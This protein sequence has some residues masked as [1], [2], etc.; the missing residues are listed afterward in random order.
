MSGY[1]DPFVLLRFPELGDD[2]SVLLRNPKL[3][4]PGD[5]TPEDVPMRDDGQPVDPQAANDAGYKVMA[6]IIV[7]W[8]IYAAPG[9][10]TDI[11]PEA[12]PED[13]LKA[14]EGV[15]LVRLGKPTAESIAKAP[16]AVIKRV[17]EEIQS[18]LDPS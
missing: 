17:M 5:I 9:M 3:L 18:T 7:A 2:C 15:E 1:A 11:D 4:P 6:N 16:V 8:K 12:D 13:V 10:G 14:L